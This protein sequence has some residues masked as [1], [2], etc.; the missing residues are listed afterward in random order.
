[1]N[2]VDFTSVAYNVVFATGGAATGVW[3]VF[4]HGV[5]NVMKDLERESH[6]DIK[7]IKHEVL[8]NSGGSLNDAIR[9]QVI[10]MVETIMERQHSIS[11][12]VATLNGKFEQHI[13]E[14]NA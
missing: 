3:Y 10:P 5:K 7:V 12:D 14:H 11:V 8:P 1:M 9:K 6:E 2:S 13:R 4:K